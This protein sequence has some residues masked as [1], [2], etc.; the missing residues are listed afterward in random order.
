M[1]EFLFGRHGVA[2][3][4]SKLKN[5]MEIKNKEGRVVFYIEDLTLIIIV[6]I[7]AFM[8]VGHC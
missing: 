3:F 1:E 8:I 7:I 2:D 4:G 6:G 5:K